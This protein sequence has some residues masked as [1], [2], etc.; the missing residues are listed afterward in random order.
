MVD[1]IKKSLDIYINYIVESVHLRQFVTHGNG[2]LSATIRSE[3]IT[4]PIKLGFA[5]R[6]HDLQHALL[7][8]PI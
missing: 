2:I 8:N 7:Y 4:V 6:L 5:Y 1:I 3:T